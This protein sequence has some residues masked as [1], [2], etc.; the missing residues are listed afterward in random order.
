MPS[1]LAMNLTA[2]VDKA[3]DYVEIELPGGAVSILF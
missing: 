1:F 2:G 3:L